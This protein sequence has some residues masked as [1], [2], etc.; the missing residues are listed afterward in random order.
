M[1]DAAWW[2]PD[3]LAVLDHRGHAHLLTLEL[4][5]DNTVLLHP[6]LAVDAPIGRGILGLTN[7]DRDNSQSTVKGAPVH[8]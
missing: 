7:V 3:T 4:T 1:A 2:S 6:K 5:D 8:V